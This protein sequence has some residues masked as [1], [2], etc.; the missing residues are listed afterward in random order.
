MLCVLKTQKK[1]LKKIIKS[2]QSIYPIARDL[3]ILVAPLLP[4]FFDSHVL[5]FRPLQINVGLYLL[6]RTIS[7]SPATANQI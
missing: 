7:L 2:P 5:S 3:F 4:L 6:Y 1:R